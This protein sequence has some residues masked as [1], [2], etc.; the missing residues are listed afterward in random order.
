MLSNSDEEI[1]GRKLEDLVDGSED[2]VD[3]ESV[4]RSNMVAERLLDMLRDYFE[5]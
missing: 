3:G 2:A 4:Q 1:D 5:N